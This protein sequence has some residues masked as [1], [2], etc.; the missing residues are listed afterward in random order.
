MRAC[1]Y[2][3]SVDNKNENENGN[4]NENSHVLLGLRTV[5]NWVRLN[6]VII[7]IL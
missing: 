3:N 7:R 2:H 1:L 5:G 6:G 4:E